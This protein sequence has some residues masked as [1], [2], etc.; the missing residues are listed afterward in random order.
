MFCLIRTLFLR[1]IN[2]INWIFFYANERND[3]LKLFRRIFHQQ[4][5]WA[6]HLFCIRVLFLAK[7]YSRSWDSLLSPF[8]PFERLSCPH[9]KRNEASRFFRTLVINYERNLR[10]R[11]RRRRYRSRPR[12]GEEKRG[13]RRRRSPTCGWS[14]RDEPRW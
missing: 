4:V 14:Y 11:R 8:S 5:I 3:Y 2:F 13:R 1:S 6:I 12:D 7:A 9:E 10:Q